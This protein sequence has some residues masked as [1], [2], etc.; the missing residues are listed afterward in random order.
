[1][2][3][4]SYSIIINNINYYIQPTTASHDDD[5]TLPLDEFFR[6]N[7][8]T[9]IMKR[10]RYMDIGETILTRTTLKC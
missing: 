7:G 9:A 6:E 2:K 8:R 3:L 4:S 1:M 5:E 10:L